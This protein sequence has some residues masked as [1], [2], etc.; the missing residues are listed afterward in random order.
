M[1]QKNVKAWCKRCTTFGHCKATVRGRSELQQARHGA[2]NARVLV[3]L[4]GPLHSTDRG[5]EYIVVMQGHFTK[6]IEAQTA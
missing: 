6:W 4:I 5:N 1:V 2:I 3:D